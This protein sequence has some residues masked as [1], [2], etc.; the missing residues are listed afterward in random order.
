[1]SRGVIISSRNSTAATVAEQFLTD[2]LCVRFGLCGEE[3]DTILRDLKGKSRSVVLTGC[4][5]YRLITTLSPDALA[6]PFGQAVTITAH[7]SSMGP[8]PTG[9]VKFL[10]GT[11]GIG[12]ATLSDGVAKLTKSN[13]AVGTHPITPQYL[14]DT[15]SDKSTSSV[16]NQVAH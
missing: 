14:G 2:E 15:A 13:L 3:Y 1:M 16:L 4:D 11:T 8:A 6:S 7:V 12:L 5:G 10:D 9:S